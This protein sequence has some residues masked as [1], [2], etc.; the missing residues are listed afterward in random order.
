MGAH[1]VA[2]VAVH[3]RYRQELN[4][5]QINQPSLGLW[6]VSTFP[7]LLYFQYPINYGPKLID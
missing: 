6:P 5:D 3:S 4:L 2:A 7:V 1:D